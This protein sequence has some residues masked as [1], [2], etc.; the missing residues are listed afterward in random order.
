MFCEACGGLLLPGNG[1]LYCRECKI[2]YPMKLIMSEESKHKKKILNDLPDDLANTSVEARCRKCGNN[3]AF[4][5]FKQMRSSD[6][7]PTK[8]FKCTKCGSLWRQYE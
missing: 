5:T 8:F 7:G 2:E 6:E 4:F 3:R 1:V